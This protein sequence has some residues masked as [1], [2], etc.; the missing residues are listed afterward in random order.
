VSSCCSFYFAVA[1]VVVVVGV[2]NYEYDKFLRGCHN[3]KPELRLRH[4]V[5]CE[6]R[7]ENAQRGKT[8]KN[9]DWLAAKTFMAKLRAIRAKK[10]EEKPLEKRENASMHGGGKCKVEAVQM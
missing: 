8:N 1:V 2:F 3:N 10:K 4:C 6:K 9:P 5:V 7:V